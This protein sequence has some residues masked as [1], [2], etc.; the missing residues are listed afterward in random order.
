MAY[1]SRYKEHSGFLH[2]LSFEAEKV[3]DDGLMDDIAAERA[4][5]GIVLEETAD[6]GE[7]QN[8]WSKAVEDA[9]KDPQWNFTNDEDNEPLY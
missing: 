6:P 2:T 5:E 3:T 8:F 7:L 4:Q 1:F 9:R